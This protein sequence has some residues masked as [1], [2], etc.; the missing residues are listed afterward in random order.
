MRNK[1]LII[2]P[3]FI[4][5]LTTLIINDFYLK[6]EY[7][8]WITGKLSDFAGLLI[9]PL[10]IAYIFPGIKRYAA[11]ITGIIFLVWKLPV[12]TPFIDLIN[13]Y[14][15]LFIVERV[16]DYSDYIAFLILPISHYLI[17]SIKGFCPINFSL[18]RRFTK[19]SLL[20]V[21]FFAFCS[22]SAHWRFPPQGTIFI[23]KMYKIKLPKDSVI[24]RIN[25]LGYNCDYYNDTI[26]IYGQDSS[27]IFPGYYQTDN[28]LAVWKGSSEID[29]LSNI[30]YYLNEVSSKET[31]IEIINVTLPKQGNI[32]NWKYLK[33][34]SKKYK[35]LVKYNLIDKIN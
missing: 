20:V 15:S 7:G 21:A 29:T 18:M 32:Q 12:T 9:F 31:K 30:K 25:A 6:Q 10:F 4:I 16:I 13:S 35:E 14:Q 2:N 26:E 22:T 28:L 17:N 24:S 8:N 23:G 33:S 27:L 3:Y 34:L 11:L 1:E 19:V 5:G